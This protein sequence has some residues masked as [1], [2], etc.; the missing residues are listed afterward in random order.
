MQNKGVHYVLTVVEMLR[1]RRGLLMASWFSS[2]IPKVNES[3]EIMPVIITFEMHSSEPLSSTQK[4]N[5]FW[6]Q[7]CHRKN[8]HSPHWKDCCRNWAGL[9]HPKGPGSGSTRNINSVSMHLILMIWLQSVWV[10]W[11]EDESKQMSKQATCTLNVP[12]QLWQEWAE[13]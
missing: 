6:I 11:I 1:K 4:V 12:F 10:T 8:H 3:S 9:V 2:D 7:R 5:K 13:P